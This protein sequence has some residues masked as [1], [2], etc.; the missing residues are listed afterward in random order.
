VE[1]INCVEVRDSKPIVLNNPL[2]FCM[3]IPLSKVSMRY[4]RN[5]S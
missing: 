5:P 1:K 3:T 4:K 2:W